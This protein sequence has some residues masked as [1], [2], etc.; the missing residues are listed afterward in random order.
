MYFALKHIHVL[1]AVISIV[2]F[3]IRGALRLANS[4][5]LQK[6]WIRIV[7]HII[8]TLL[9]L[10]AIGLTITIHQYPITTDWLSAK[11]IGLIVYIGLGVV[12]LRTAKTQP[13]RIVAYLLAIVTFGYVAAVAVTKSPLF[14]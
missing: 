12:T 13:V 9:L 4:S 7:P 14:F 5:V 8:D 1:C 6:K 10:S 2:G 11:L 3:I